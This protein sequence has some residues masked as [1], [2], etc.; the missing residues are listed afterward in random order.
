LEGLTKS[1]KGK[2]SV[3][4]Q[5]CAKTK[6]KIKIAMRRR[7]KNG[8]SMISLFGGRKKI[9]ILILV[10]EHFCILVPNNVNYIKMK[11]LLKKK[12]VDFNIIEGN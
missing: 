3:K 6:I 5:K 1:T 7:W 10:L 9:A 8:F 2:K 4:R 12:N 11:C